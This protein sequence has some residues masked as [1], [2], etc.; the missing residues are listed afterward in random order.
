MLTKV[1][2]WIFIDL[3]AD[4][5]IQTFKEPD[6]VTRWAWVGASVQGPRLL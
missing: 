4:E 6:D 1:Y 3:K 5:D 2:S